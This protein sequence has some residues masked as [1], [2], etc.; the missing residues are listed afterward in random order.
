MFLPPPCPD[1]HKYRVSESTAVTCFL[2]MKYVSP[3]AEVVE[4]VYSIVNDKIVS[5]TNKDS[6]GIIDPHFMLIC[7]LFGFC[8]VMFWG[9]GSATQGQNETEIAI[10]IQMKPPPD[11]GLFKG[12]VKG[13]I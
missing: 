10:C 1:Q 3:L 7:S 9:R 11:C 2:A 8:P 12:E 5:E 4:V 13:C 6:L